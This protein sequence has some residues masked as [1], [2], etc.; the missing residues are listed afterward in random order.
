MLTIF[1]EEALIDSIEEFS[2]TLKSAH[3]KTEV[4]IEKG[5]A[6]EDFLIEKL[7][8]YEGKSEGTKLIESWL[9]ERL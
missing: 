9:A 2:K 7:L 4:V 1:L 8:G 5:A 3:P 6:R